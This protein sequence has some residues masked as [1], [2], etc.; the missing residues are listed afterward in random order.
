MMPNYEVMQFIVYRQDGFAVSNF[1]LVSATVDSNRIKTNADL[2]AAFKAG[3]T[4]WAKNTEEGKAAYEYAGSDMNIGD[5]AGHNIE[6]I[7]AL[8]CAGIKSMRIQQIDDAS[9]WMY[10]T[11][12]CEEIDTEDDEDES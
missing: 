8:Y 1:M 2:V 4:E 10:D 9:H 7:I 6:P 12:L 3:V 11:S 5:L